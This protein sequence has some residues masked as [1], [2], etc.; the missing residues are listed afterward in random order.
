VIPAQLQPPHATERRARTTAIGRA[1]RTQ[2]GTIG[3]P[4]IPG[5]RDSK[6]SGGIRIHRER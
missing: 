4:A 3:T 2:N 6:Q 1:A 5:A